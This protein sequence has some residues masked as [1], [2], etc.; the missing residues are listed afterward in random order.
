MG[1]LETS[2]PSFP[3]LWLC[4]ASSHLCL[5]L[6]LKI[7]FFLHSCEVSL[8]SLRPFS[9]NN[10]FLPGRF[11]HIFTCCLQPAQWVL[12]SALLT[13]PGLLVALP[14]SA[15]RVQSALLVSQLLS[16]DTSKLA[17]LGWRG[18][19]PARV[20]RKSSGKGSRQA[21]VESNQTLCGSLL[22]SVNVS[23]YH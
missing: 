12:L 1:F 23:K 22:T 20:C 9:P 18:R 6:Q 13:C 3:A 16:W 5:F 7:Y 4:L 17:E 15:D 14:C 10:Q 19:S 8:G 21:A 11:S 2:S